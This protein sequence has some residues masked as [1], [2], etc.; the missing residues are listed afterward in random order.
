MRDTLVVITPDRGGERCNYE[1]IES[2]QK[3]RKFGTYDEQAKTATE[4]I[5]LYHDYR[6]LQNY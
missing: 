5:I 2:E 4:T 6:K 3:Y 1:N